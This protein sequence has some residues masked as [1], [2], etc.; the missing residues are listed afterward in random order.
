MSKKDEK[1]IT[2][3]RRESI[4]KEAT[5]LFYT[6]GYDNA[7]I[8]ELTNAVGLS[9]AG[10]Y[11]F[12]KDKE[13][14]LFTILNQSIDDLNDTI[15]GALREKDDPQKNLKRLIE[16]LLRH[17]IKHKLEISILN[18]ED[19]RLSEEQKD[20]INRK[21]R[22]AFS[23]VKN[24]LSRLEKQGKI[25]TKSLT[26]AAFFIFSMT[27]WFVRWYKP[28]GLMTLEEIADEMSDILLNG[29]LK[30]PERE[31]KEP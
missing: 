31:G 18:R 19:G 12:F 7:S 8:R 23:L 4:I 15:K 16:S 11:Y 29:I 13:E 3:D 26:T 30:K 14:I 6:K 17:V 9:V 1:K 5:L 24:E 27:T 28:D 2:V 22:I 21:R 25:A 20:T 10:V